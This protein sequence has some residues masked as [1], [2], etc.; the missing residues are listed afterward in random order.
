MNRIP[1]DEAE[2]ILRRAIEFDADEKNTLSVE[3]LHAIARELNISSSAVER[4]ISSEQHVM[5]ATP[6]P[7]PSTGLA[8]SIL[9]PHHMAIVGAVLMIAIEGFKI[10]G[11]GA[12]ATAFASMAVYALAQRT[13]GKRISRIIRGAASFWL[14]AVL[15]SMLFESPTPR[16]IPKVLM[17][18]AISCGIGIAAAAL[19]V[20][21][22][23]HD[24]AA[25]AGGNQSPPSDGGGNSSGGGDTWR[26]RMLKRIAKWLPGDPMSSAIV[27][28][29]ASVFRT[30]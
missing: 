25:S 17:Y 24:T 1:R 22:E 18:F 23:E 8:P 4:A 13:P 12:L 27:D 16:I 11:N 29:L 9:H 3:E 2:I 10:D 6:A 28:R 26:V 30:A 19:R 21:S 15:T 5:R 14:S 7:V 20:L